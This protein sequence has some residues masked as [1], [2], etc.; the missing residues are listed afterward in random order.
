MFHHFCNAV[1]FW[2]VLF[3]KVHHNMFSLMNVVLHYFC[4]LF[5]FSYCLCI[6]STHALLSCSL[7]HIVCSPFLTLPALPL[8]PLQMAILSGLLLF[9]HCWRCCWYK[10]RSTPFTPRH[11]APL[12]LHL[13]TACARVMQGLVHPHS[14]SSAHHFTPYW[15]K[16]NLD[17]T[18]PCSL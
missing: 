12:R 15:L 10:H 11:L 16:H 14:T 9:L 7:F 4:L 13:C 6:I 5:L 1:S 8:H 3:V 17:Q 2:F 18:L